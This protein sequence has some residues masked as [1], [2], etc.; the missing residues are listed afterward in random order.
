M[1]PQR[2]IIKGLFV[3]ECSSAEEGNVMHG[4]RGW[5]FNPPKAK[6]R[7]LSGREGGGRRRSQEARMLPTFKWEG[8]P[9]GMSTLAEEWGRGMNFRNVVVNGTLEIYFTMEDL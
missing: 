2:T 4:T 9:S 6:P 1:D 7:F 3:S 8:A 5:A